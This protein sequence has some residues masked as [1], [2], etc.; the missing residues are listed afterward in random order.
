VDISERHCGYLVE[1]AGSSSLKGTGAL[2]GYISE[3]GGRSSTSE[4]HIDLDI[5]VAVIFATGKEYKLLVLIKD[6]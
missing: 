2:T 3:W 5:V 4:G 1:L 6:K